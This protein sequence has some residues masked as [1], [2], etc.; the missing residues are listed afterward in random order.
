MTSRGETG[1]TGNKGDIVFFYKQFD[2]SR[3]QPR[4]SE[5]GSRMA[6]DVLKCTKMT[7]VPLWVC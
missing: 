1:L 6:V 5:N 7:V 4:R 3:D 2:C